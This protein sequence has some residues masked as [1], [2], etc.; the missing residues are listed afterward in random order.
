M[1]SHLHIS[2]YQQSELSSIVSI[3]FPATPDRDNRLTDLKGERHWHLY[4]VIHVIG[5]GT[6]CKIPGKWKGKKTKHECACFVVS[7]SII[8]Q[9]TELQGVT[10][11]KGSESHLTNKNMRT[12]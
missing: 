10:N 12:C 7:L 11:N 8:L 4:S 9:F 6:M 1:L 2:E 5:R 3:Q